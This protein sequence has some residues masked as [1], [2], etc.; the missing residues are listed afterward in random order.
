MK[1]A[2]A[3][4]IW[5]SFEGVEWISQTKRII[6]LFHLSALPPG[7]LIGSCSRLKSTA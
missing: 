6:K 3:D 5:A 4:F 1:S 7:R 2:P